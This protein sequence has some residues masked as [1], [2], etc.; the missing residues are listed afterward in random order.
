MM[1]K[2]PTR[3][4][5]GAVLLAALCGLPQPATARTPLMDWEAGR[6]QPIR[7]ARSLAERKGRLIEKVRR[8]LSRPKKTFVGADPRAGTYVT[9]YRP[10]DKTISGNYTTHYRTNLIPLLGHLRGGAGRRP[11]ALKRA[12]FAWDSAFVSNYYQTRIKPGG[13]GAGARPTLRTPT[14]GLRYQHSAHARGPY[15]RTHSGEMNVLSPRVAAQISRSVAA[16]A[17]SFRGWRSSTL[18]SLRVY[19]NTRG[20]AFF[21]KSHLSTSVYFN[22]AAYYVNRR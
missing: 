5:V 10:Q 12:F 6:Y 1:L 14:L 21:P 4:V 11:M 15:A 18:S 7:P 20:Y 16:S 13:R 8:T 3:A 22:A 19:T 17:A 9:N 2:T